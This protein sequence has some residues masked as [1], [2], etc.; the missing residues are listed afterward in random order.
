MASISQR[1]T[2]PACGRTCWPRDLNLDDAGN[3][4]SDPV[5]Y[6]CFVKTKHVPG[7]GKL[8]Y[9]TRED[10]PRHVLA[11]VRAQLVRALAYVDGL[12]E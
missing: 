1:V 5:T 12:L 3:P 4:V 2:C 11:G 6:G 10:M 9:W 8:L 7:G